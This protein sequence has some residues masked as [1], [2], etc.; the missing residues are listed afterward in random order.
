MLRISFHSKNN[1]KKHFLGIVECLW[2]IQDAVW[3]H[4]AYF[5]KILCTHDDMDMDEHPSVH[6]IESDLTSKGVSHVL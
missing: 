1:D 5:C 4:A 2:D 3:P 6:D